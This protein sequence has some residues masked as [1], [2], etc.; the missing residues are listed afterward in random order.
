MFHSLYRRRSTNKHNRFY[1]LSSRKVSVFLKKPKY[2][3]IGLVLSVYPMGSVSDPLTSSYNPSQDQRIYF[4]GGSIR[5]RINL[6][7]FGYK[8][9]FVVC[10]D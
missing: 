7:E 3:R 6:V 9:S 2:S 8:N 4:I 1:Y 10:F 5:Y